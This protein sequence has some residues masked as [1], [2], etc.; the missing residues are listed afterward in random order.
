LS[1]LADPIFIPF[2]IFC[3]FVRKRGKISIATN[4]ANLWRRKA[5]RFVEVLECLKSKEE[6]E[7][8]RRYERRKR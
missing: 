1:A 7:M 6:Q 5:R 8:K 3:N 2:F 4:E